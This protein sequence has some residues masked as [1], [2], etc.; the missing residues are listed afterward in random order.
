MSTPHDSLSHFTPQEVQ[1]YDSRIPAL[2]PGYHVLHHSSA[3]LLKTMLPAGGRVLVVGAGTGAELLALQANNLHWPCTAVEPMPEMLALGRAKCAAA[4]MQNVTWHRAFLHELP[5]GA[6]H[7]A[8]LCQLVLHFIATPQDKQRLLSDIASRLKPGASLL[9]CDLLVTDPQER[10]A[11]IECA[12]SLGM[13]GQRREIMRQRLQ[14]DF[15]P[16]SEP[17]LAQLAADSGFQAPQLFF[18]TLCFGGWLLRRC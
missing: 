1:H 5:P 15:F 18:R 11:L 8:A 3:A 7:D 12:V 14:D 2:V 16:L 17:Q 13:P 9:L 6:P 4:G 10:S